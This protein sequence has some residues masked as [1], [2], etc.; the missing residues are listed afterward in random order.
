MFQGAKIVVVAALTSDH[1]P[2]V[3]SLLD[4]QMPKRNLHYFKYEAHW[5]LNKECKDIVKQVWRRKL[6]PEDKWQDFNQKVKH[7]KNQLRRW[8]NMNNGSREQ[9][10]VR[11]KEELLTLQGAEG[12]PNRELLKRLQAE[13]N[14]LLAQ[15]DLHWHQ[16]SKEM[17]LKCGDKNTK[18]FHA[19][20]TQ[21]KRKNLIQKIQDS[22]GRVWENG[23][24]VEKAFVEY[25][26]NLFK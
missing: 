22:Q 20:A 9:E 2:L 5:G 14:L 23:E 3:I 24:G 6:A 13:A 1:A 4:H 10:I 25:Y 12:L 19:C 11:I 17:W 26:A 18:Y 15:E 7:C 16:R 21:R 8:E